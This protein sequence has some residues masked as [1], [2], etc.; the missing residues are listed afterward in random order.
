MR[1]AG[2]MDPELNNPS[3]EP[4]SVSPPLVPGFTPI[5]KSTISSTEHEVAAPT[6]GAGKPRKGKVA[7]PAATA[8]SQGRKRKS[9]NSSEVKSDSNKPAKKPR[10]RNVRPVGQGTGNRTQNISKALVIRKPGLF[11][12]SDTTHEKATE[13]VST[14]GSPSDNQI[15][16]P[17]LSQAY[18]KAYERRDANSINRAD[19]RPPDF[20]NFFDDATEAGA[21]DQVNINP[22]QI[23]R[24]TSGLENRDLDGQIVKHLDEPILAVPST[25]RSST[26]CVSE[27]VPH[28]YDSTLCDT[29]SDAYVLDSF[30]DDGFDEVFDSV[31]AAND[32]KL[33]VRDSSATE[34]TFD[35]DD[36]D[37]ELLQVEPTAPKHNN[38]ESPPFTQRTPPVPRLQWTPPTPPMPPTPTKRQQLS[39]SLVNG[40][41]PTTL[42]TRSSPLGEKSPNVQRHNVSA[43][44]GHLTPFARSP[45]PALL[46]S[47]RPVSGLSPELSLRVCF[48]IGE[49]VNAASRALRCSND[50]IIELYCR[51]KHSHREVNSHRQYFEFCDLFHPDRP[52]FLN[53]Q[54]AIWKGIGLWEYDSRQF[55][56]ENCEMKMAR[57]VGR[58]KRGDANRGWQMTVLSIWATNWEDIE[59]VK[60]VV[61]S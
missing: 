57:V 29:N 9:T 35:D 40:T 22:A 30:A 34:D 4:D 2:I 6:Q 24:F 1:A 26:C 32:T 37:A 42:A 51:V 16:R 10:Q 19:Y 60:G 13:A 61:C 21:S 50:A 59:V 18:Q 31:S 44:N 36:L 53:G 11:N 12:G 48:R 28:V 39:R 23:D 14:E 17:G 27:P 47:R 7:K 3:M 5:N 55:L 20:T 33:P 58:V 43:E 25:L 41:S 45:F 49:A 46:L 8:S 38:G 56:G 15:T 54:Y 52:P